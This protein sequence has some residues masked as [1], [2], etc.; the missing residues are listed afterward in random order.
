MNNFVAKHNFNRPCTHRVK[1]QYS[2]KWEI[3]WDEIDPPIAL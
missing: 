2:R 1:T 3:D